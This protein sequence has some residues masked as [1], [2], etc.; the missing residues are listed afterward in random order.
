MFPVA[1]SHRSRKS[2]STGIFQREKL[3]M[4]NFIQKLRDA[5]KDENA[6]FAQLYRFL[7][8]L[9]TPYFPGLVRQK[10]AQQYSKGTIVC[11]RRI[12]LGFHIRVVL[13]QGTAVFL[14]IW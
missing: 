8:L 9:Q 2:A 1:L 12:K 14:K 4:H 5:L 3:P 13:G 7:A 6:V 10:H 11:S